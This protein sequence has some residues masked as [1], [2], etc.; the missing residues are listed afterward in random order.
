MAE[1]VYALAGWASSA[2][3]FAAD[4]KAARKPLC[5]FRAQLL[6]Q[7]IQMRQVI[8]TSARSQRRRSTPAVGHVRRPPRLGNSTS[9][10]TRS[11]G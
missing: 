2:G 6:A 1:S 8:F 9:A 7:E 4:D 10:P 5:F 3:N 11:A